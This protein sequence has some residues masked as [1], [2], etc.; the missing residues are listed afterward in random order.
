[1]YSLE[2]STP[3]GQLQSLPVANLKLVTPT[4]DY[5]LQISKHDGTRKAV[6]DNDA[7]RPEPRYPSE[8]KR[9]RPNLKVVVTPATVDISSH[10]SFDPRSASAPT[11][12][13]PLPENTFASASEWNHAQAPW[14][15]SLPVN[16]PMVPAPTKPHGR[17]LPTRSC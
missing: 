1:M 9:R 17:E 13:T 2:S 3:N 11:G 14:A 12:I 7:Q 16:F 15:T 6:D 10:I 5:S 4:P 8:H